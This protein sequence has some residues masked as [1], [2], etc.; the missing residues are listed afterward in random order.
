MAITK[1]QAVL[2]SK[3]PRCRPGNMCQGAAYG[4][5]KQRMNELCPHW[6]IEVESEPGCLCAALYVSYGFSG[7]QV[8]V[9]ALLIAYITQSESP[10]L[11]VGVLFFAIFIFAPFNYRYSRLILLHYLSPKITFNPNLAEPKKDTV[12]T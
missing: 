1:F 9:L 8:V 11:Y 7:A 3:C 6:G 12:G 4:V 2:H 10:W 5:K